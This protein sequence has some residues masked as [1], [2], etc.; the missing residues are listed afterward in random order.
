M[1]SIFE[2]IRQSVANLTTKGKSLLESIV[3]PQQQ[4]QAVN[5]LPAAPSVSESFRKS[6][7]TSPQQTYQRVEKALNTQS[8]A[9]SASLDNLK[10]MVNTSLTGIYEKTIKP[11]LDTPI[12]SVTP[13]TAPFASLNRVANVPQPTVGNVGIGLARQLIYDPQKGLFPGGLLAKI[14]EL[15][16]AKE[17]YKQ[18][19]IALPQLREQEL[20]T[21]ML[22]VVGMTQEGIKSV[23]PQSRLQNL[24]TYQN[25]LRS[26]G[27]SAEQ[28]R[29][30]TA[31]EAANLIEKQVAPFAHPSFEKTKV[32]KKMLEQQSTAPSPLMGTLAEKDLFKNKNVAQRLF[33]TIFRPV[34]NTPP[35]IQN[36]VSSWRS[37]VLSGRQK[38]NALASQFATIPQEDAFKL[39]QYIQEPSAATAKRVGLTSSQIKGYMSVID[40]IRTTYDALRNEGIK[41]GLPIG[42]LENYLNNV[43]DN[44]IEEIARKLQSG[45]RTPYFSKER[46]IPNYFEGITKYQLTPRYTHP[47][48]LVAHY[49][50]AL[51]RAVAN[52]ELVKTLEKSGY[53]TSSNQAPFHWKPISAPLFP[54]ATIRTRGGSF[55]QVP[56][57]APP[58]ITNVINNIFDRSSGPILETAGKIS[59]FLQNLTL[60]GGVPGTPINAFTLG[61]MIKEVTAGKPITGA[62]AFILSFSDDTANAYFR[63]NEGILQKMAKEG[64]PLSTSADYG[65]R[66]ANALKQSSIKEIAGQKFHELVDK[67]TFQR[68]YPLLQIDAFKNVYESAVKR[69]LGEEAAS[70]LAGG[71]IKNF[72]GIVDELATGRSGAVQDALKTF[73]F[74]PKFRESMV[75]FWVNNVKSILPKNFLNPEF[76]LNRRFLAGLAATLTL[77]DG[78]NYKLNGHH[79][80][81]NPSGKELTLLVPVNEKTTLG[82]PIL[83]SVGTL[84]RVAAS[85]LSNILK[86]DIEKA[87]LEL[88]KASSSLVKPFIDIVANEDYFGR[89][90]Y[91]EG[92]SSVEKYKKQLVYLASQ[93]SHP[94][95]NA[96][97]RGIQNQASPAEIVSTALEAPVRFYKS[98]QI[99]KSLD[100]D[101]YFKL[102]P[103]ASEYRR[104]EK[105]D[106]RKAQEYY[107]NHQK[108]I[109]QFV[110][111]S[112]I[113]SLYSDMKTQ[114]VT[115]GKK[116][117]SLL[118]GQ[119]AS[120]KEYEKANLRSHQLKIES[121]PPQ[122]RIRYIVTGLKDGSLTKEG[123]K[124]IAQA[125]SEP[126]LQQE[127]SSLKDQSVNV[128]A[129]FIL[130]TIR[131][132]MPEQKAAYLIELS[133]KK[134]L[135]PGVAAALKQLS[136]N[137][138][139]SISP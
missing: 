115:E 65:G 82:V 34:K 112:P 10:R 56:Y 55:T 67:P 27:Y 70:K 93:Y 49:Q 95:I 3:V 53:F 99:A 16:K 54:Q 123:L 136:T 137:Q 128:R 57:K 11:I 75:N 77:Y 110:Y 1:Q 17:D 133:K 42:Y 51:D 108:E 139:L 94:Y 12:L 131:P 61:Q 38:A 71:T 130:E 47:A 45:G 30:I 28:I 4:K 126:K 86:G 29:K 73:T 117:L 87:G 74:A 118:K 41:K 132:M 124:K 88:R 13:F 33:D 106:P 80:W 8:T 69:G 76:G 20:E 25:E 89:Q 21:A 107:K 63:A 134:I 92:D 96:V 81:E 113:V 120:T 52:A 85:T 22:P 116:K 102:K 39:V 104:L 79:L 46:L 66:F 48:Q 78:L 18:G 68:F 111:L 62:K 37:S 129:K 23:T 90:I 32:Y 119:E 43:W 24:L 9:N 15:A 2:K 19:K 36:A 100:Y 7:L 31:K 103:V 135:T 97:V 44:P 26:M 64:I 101:Q 60:S 58:E 114:E 122:E 138:L 84:P 109:L 91:K 105:E 5:A 59:S 50:E 83:P 14:G 98:D 125:M 127:E 121:L 35:E 40:K 72:Y 6:L